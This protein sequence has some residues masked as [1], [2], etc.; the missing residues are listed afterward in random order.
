M[1]FSA[2]KNYLRGRTRNVEKFFAKFEEIWAIIWD[3]LY[4][5]VLSDLK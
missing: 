1:L 4:K 3:F 2:L 5:T